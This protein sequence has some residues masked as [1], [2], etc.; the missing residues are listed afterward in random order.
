MGVNPNPVFRCSIAR[1]IDAMAG[2]TAHGRIIVGD[3]KILLIS[4]FY[5]A[6]RVIC[7]RRIEGRNK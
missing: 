6:S 4:P 5:C 7:H 1:I 2:R 3:S